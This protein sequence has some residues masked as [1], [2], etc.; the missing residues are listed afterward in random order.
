[1]RRPVPLG[2]FI[3]FGSVQYRTT[4]DEHSFRWP[5]SRVKPAFLIARLPSTNSMKRLLQRL[6]TGETYLQESPTPTPGPN[7]I[8]VGSRASLV[9]AGTERMLVDF[10]RANLLQKARQQPQR[11]KDVLDKAQRDGIAATL[12]AVRSKLGQPLALGYCQSGVV[13]AVG[14]YVS[15]FGV[16]DRVI[17]NGPHAEQVAVSR[18]LSAKIPDG[19]DFETAAFTPLAAIALQGI[20]LAEPQIGDNVIVYGLGLIGLLSVQILRAAGCR[21]FGVDID[22]QRLELASGYGAAPVDPRSQDVPA[23]I[24]AATGGHGADAALLTLSAKSDEPVHLAAEAVRK[25][26]KLVLVG[27]TGLNLRREDFYGKELSFQVSCSYGPGRYDPKYEKKAQD[28]PLPYVRW[29]E[30]RNF[31]AVLQLMADRSI[32]VGKLISHRMPFDEAPKGYDMLAQGE[33]LGI[34]FEYSEK[35]ADI[36]QRSI[37]VSAPAPLGSKRP[38]LA[39]IGAGNFAVRTLLPILAEQNVRLHTLVSRGGGDASVAASKFGFERVGTDVDEVLSDPGIDAVMILTRHDSHGSLSTAA[40]NAGKHVFVEK[41]LGLTE[42][43]VTAVVDAAERNNR[44]LMVGFNRRFAPL[45]RAMKK[46]VD[47]RSG[48]LVTMIKV[49]AG[50][51]PR[52]HWVHDPAVGGGRIVGEACHWIDLARFWA[53]SPITG[54]RITFAKDH[55]GQVI[56][57]VATINLDFEDGSIAVISYLACGSPAVPKERMEC[58]FDERTVSLENWRRFRTWDRSLHAP[59]SMGRP[60][61]GHAEALKAFTDAVGLGATCPIPLAELSEVALAAMPGVSLEPGEES[62][63]P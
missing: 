2:C 22:P 37:Q 41:P 11:V 6:D 17:T 43:E 3:R 35:Q 29:T 7:E 36:A 42:A 48:P 38:T 26:G 39:V 53:G 58:V 31:D 15:D 50:Q 14:S 19:V 4:L 60:K 30:Q 28:Y 33:G 62:P 61:K 52:D 21:V 47:R 18:L 34:L 12:D 10:G 5:E 1:M 13:L 16:G 24:Q 55:A 27:V 49:S 20:R 44:I 54:S 32:D 51:I 40:L 59:W 57:D 63:R 56:D 25:R 46:E 23:S 45:A 8:V 9:S